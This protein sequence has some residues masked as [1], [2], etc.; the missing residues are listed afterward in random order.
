MLVSLAH[1]FPQRVTEWL[2]S[3]FM[4]SWGLSC[5]NSPQAAFDHPVYVE[6]AKIAPIHIWGTIAFVIG[7]A[8]VCALFINGAVQRSPHARALG[9]F[10]SN[11]MWLQLAL[12]AIGADWSGPTTMVYPWLFA[13]DFYNVFRAARDARLSDSLAMS[14]RALENA[15][16]A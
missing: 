1:H 10:V 16:R 2:V 3:G 13:A 15:E 9:A 7:M 8:R 5:L 14:R 6:I 4:I 11:F 12:G